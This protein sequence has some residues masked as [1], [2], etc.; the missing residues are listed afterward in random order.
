MATA[1]SS[2][3]PKITSQAP[4]ILGANSIHFECV[5]MAVVARAFSW[6]DLVSLRLAWTAEQVSGKLKH[7]NSDSD[8][9][10]H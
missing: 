4:G 1:M 10:L 8:P 3:A 9:G 5:N 6:E 2:L 7:E